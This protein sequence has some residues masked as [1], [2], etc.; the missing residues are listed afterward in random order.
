M[1]QLLPFPGL[2][3]TSPLF[4]WQIV[5]L[6]EKLGAPPDA[7]AAVM[8]H[9]SGFSPSIRNTFG[10]PGKIATDTCGAVGLIQFMPTTS[11]LLHTKQ[12]LLAAMT[13]EE[14][15]AYVEAFFDMVTRGKQLTRTVDV[16][17]A[18]IGPAYIGKSYDTVIYASPDPRYEGNKW[19]DLDKDGMLTVAEMEGV[20]AKDIAEAKGRIA[21]V[22]M[23]DATEPPPGETLVAGASPSA[24][25]PLAFAAGLAAGYYGVA[26]YL[27][28]RLR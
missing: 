17:L 9:E 28:A 2:E 14:Q 25:R 4:R 5:K 21:T 8:K 12:S 15:M 7:L 27:R 19:L 23:L 24:L 16:Y 20:M 1:A 11:A 22:G 13:R 3:N 18:T 10:C 26:R 6:A